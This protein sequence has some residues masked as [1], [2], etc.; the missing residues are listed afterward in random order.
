MIRLGA[1]DANLTLT[2]VAKRFIWLVKVH[3]TTILLKVLLTALKKT[4]SYG[5]NITL[6]R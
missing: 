2:P 3:H 6:I 4:L 5:L 1:L